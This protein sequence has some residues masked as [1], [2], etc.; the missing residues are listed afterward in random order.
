MPT[1]QKELQPQI[2]A[3]P[4]LDRP[5]AQAS[6]QMPE[7]MQPVGRSELALLKKMLRSKTAKVSSQAQAMHRV[8][9]PY[10]D[11]RSNFARRSA[12]LWWSSPS[13]TFQAK[14]PFNSNNIASRSKASDCDQLGRS[15]IP[16]T[17]EHRR[18]DEE[19]KVI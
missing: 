13:L 16:R 11:E 9:R 8:V 18:R 5:F 1:R 10:A 7:L 2:V 12:K 6:F 14:F 3:D 19:H 4:K 15:G 17:R